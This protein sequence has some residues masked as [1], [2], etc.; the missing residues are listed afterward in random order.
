MSRKDA[1]A[2]ARVAGYHSDTRRFVRLIVESRVSRPYLNEAW[3]AGARARANG[4]RCTCA[5]CN[6]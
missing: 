5:D 6:R 2:L 1:L 4:V 3:A